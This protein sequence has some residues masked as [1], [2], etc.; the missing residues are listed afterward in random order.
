MHSMLTSSVRRNDQEPIVRTA[1][2]IVC[3]F[4]HAT[5]MQPHPAREMTNNG[6][7]EDLHDG[8]SKQ[9]ATDKRPCIS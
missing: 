2:F 6:V 9:D 1:F 5:H 3:R 8:E 4:K 7:Q